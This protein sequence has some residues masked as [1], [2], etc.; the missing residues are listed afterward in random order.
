MI[1]LFAALLGLCATGMAEEETSSVHDD[2]HHTVEREHGQ[3]LAQKTDSMETHTLITSFDLYCEDCGRVIQE[4]VRT[5]QK[6]EPHKW[7]VTRE[8]PTCASEG[9]ES[10]VCAVCGAE[11]TE[12]LPLLAHEYADASLLDGRDAGTVSGTGEYAGLQIGEVTAAPTCTEQGKGTLLC[13]T[14]QTA[15]RTVILP[16]RGHDWEEWTAVLLPDD[17]ICVTEPSE[18]RRCRVCGETETRVTGPAPGHQWQE[19]VKKEATC[20]EK[21]ETRR[22]CDVCHATEEQNLPALGH[23][24]GSI[25]FFVKHEAGAVMGTGE[26]EEKL[27]GEV[28][29]PSTCTENGAGTL[30]CL[31]CQAAER[32]VVIPAGGHEW[33]EWE[34]QEI[35]EELICVTEMTGVRHCM[36]CGLE[37]TEV[38]SPA[39]GHQWL[40]VSFTEPTCTEPGRAVRQCAVCRKEEIIDSPALGHCYMWMDVKLPNGVIESEYV[41]SVCGDVAERRTRIT[42]KMYYNNTITSFGPMTRDLIGGGVWHRVTPL[43]LAEEGVFTYPLIASNLYTVGTATV[44][45]EKGTQVVNYKLN[46]YKINVH[47]ETLVFYPDLEALRTG[48]NAVV[49]EFDQ[50]IE[51]RQYFG[52]D[53]LVLMTITLRADYDAMAAGVQDFREDKE[54]IAAMSELID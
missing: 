26:K 43:N 34:Q 6:E 54:L 21:G 8:E 13:L 18:Q 2:S 9:K 31:R 51:L 5:E 47:T 39:P 33:S 25:T 15:V 48:E 1:L 3:P 49:V 28:I 23:T 38:L 22:E 12:V 32:S 35:P 40:G 37:E 10:S 41:C 16:A 44:I 27:L 45:N 52:D 24:F 17:M 19:T 53:Q 11:K 7:N 46:S 50:P 20:T 30:V 4:N 29:T 42:E 14:C 36:D